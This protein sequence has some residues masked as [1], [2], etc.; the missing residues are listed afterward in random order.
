MSIYQGVCS[1]TV[2]PGVLRYEKPWVFREVTLTPEAH[3]QLIAQMTAVGRSIVRNAE[4]FIM[5]DG[6]TV[7]IEET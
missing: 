7:K 4:G 2:V 3:E 5:L 6:I 1:Q